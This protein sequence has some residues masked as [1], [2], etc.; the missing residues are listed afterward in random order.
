MILFKY[1]KGAYFVIS[2]FIIFGIFSSCS[3]EKEVKKEK[4]PFNIQMKEQ[5]I[6]DITMAI[7]HLDSA[8]N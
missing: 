1:N 5:F 8:K 3:E 6:S 2:L 7:N 4:T